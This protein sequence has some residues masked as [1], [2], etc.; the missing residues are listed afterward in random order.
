MR[1]VNSDGKS[2]QSV[3]ITKEFGPGDTEDP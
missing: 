2:R 3:G 1:T